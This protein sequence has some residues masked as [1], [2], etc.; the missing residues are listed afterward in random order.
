MPELELHKVVHSPRT[1]TTS[2]EQPPGS[3]I[4]ELPIQEL[5]KIDYNYRQRLRP[6]QAAGEL[7][8][9]LF[10][11]LHKYDFFLTIF[12]SS[13]APTMATRAVSIE[14]SRQGIWF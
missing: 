8:G 6:L 4:A 9:G 7:V 14:G 5:E 2:T 11:Q 13:T 1:A 12:I 10:E 3:R